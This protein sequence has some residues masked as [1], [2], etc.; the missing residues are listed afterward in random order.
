MVSITKK[1]LQRGLCTSVSL[2]PIIRAQS[3]PG[4]F[5]LRHHGLFASSRYQL[6]EA[7][8]PDELPPPN[9]PDDPP[10]PEL[11]LDELVRTRREVDTSRVS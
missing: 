11:E 1:L 8:P 3:A 4:L 7:P 6:P 9:P 2:T 10:P 5:C